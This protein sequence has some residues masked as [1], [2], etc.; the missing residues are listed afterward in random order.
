MILLYLLVTH[1]TAYM[2][3]TVPLYSRKELQ[4]IS[5]MLYLEGQNR[6]LFMDYNYLV[7]PLVIIMQHF[8]VAQNYED[9]WE[10]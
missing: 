1:S 4:K 9:H 10:E 2:Q 7:K 6:E 8:P 5:S 3:K